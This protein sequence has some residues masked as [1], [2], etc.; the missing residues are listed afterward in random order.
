M[1]SLEFAAQIEVQFLWE[2]F[3]RTFGLRELSKGLGLGHLCGGWHRN[4]VARVLSA[5]IRV[6]SSLRFRVPRSKLQNFGDD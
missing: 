3:E 1:T 6:E 4:L 5:M 2:Q